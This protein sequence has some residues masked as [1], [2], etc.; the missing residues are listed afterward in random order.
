MKS[1]G[2]VRIQS[3]PAVSSFLS[4]NQG[5]ICQ[6]EDLQDLQNVYYMYHNV[7]MFTLEKA[8]PKT[9]PQSLRS[10]LSN[11]GEGVGGESTWEKKTSMAVNIAD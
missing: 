1:M 3:E 9:L 10:L 8:K 11:R 2:I 7:L 4:I 5:L 6:R